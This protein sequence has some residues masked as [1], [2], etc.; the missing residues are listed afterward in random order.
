[1]KKFNENYAEILKNN[2]EYIL[3]KDSFK[4]R[5]V[6]VLDCNGVI[7][8]GYTELIDKTF[9][10]KYNYEYEDMICIEYNDKEL[11]LEYG[12]YEF[13]D[14]L[15]EYIRDSKEILKLNSTKEFYG[16]LW[17][18][19]DFNGT[20]EIKNNCSLK[21]EYV[22]EDSKD[23]EIATKDDYEK[24]LAEAIEQIKDSVKSKISALEEELKALNELIE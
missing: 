3:E 18:D 21:V 23:Y 14:H 11:W 24:E 12:E 20:Y 19:Y 2:G 10:I 17:L 13:V 9:D 5:K 22:L 8:S 15:P 4:F 1:M 6:K 7:N 16:G